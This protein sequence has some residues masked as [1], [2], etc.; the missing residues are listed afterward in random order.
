[1]PPSRL[2]V[3]TNLGEQVPAVSKRYTSG[4]SPNPVATTR[5]VPSGE[6]AT[7]VGTPRPFFSVTGRDWLGPLRR[8]DLVSYT[9]HVPSRETAASRLPSGEKASPRTAIGAA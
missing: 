1:M 8:S 3:W 6:K 5:W 7:A 2:L 4:D 9:T